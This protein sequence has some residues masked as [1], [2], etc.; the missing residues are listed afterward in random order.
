MISLIELILELN[1]TEE[2]TIWQTYARKFG[3]RNT[4]GQTRYFKNKKKATKFARGSTKGPKVGRPEPKEK[5]ERKEDK[6]KYDVTP[7]WSE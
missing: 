7:G 2:R 6:K 4:V 1:D 5:P 3:A